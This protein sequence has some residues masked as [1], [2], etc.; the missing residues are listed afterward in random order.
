MKLLFGVDPVN[1][2]NTEEQL[3]K[4]VPLEKAL[5][6]FD[7]K[8]LDILEKMLPHIQCGYRNYLV[9]FKVRN[10]GKGQSGCPVPGW[11]YDCVRDK[12]HPSRN[13]HHLL[14][15]NVDGTLFMCE[16]GTQIKAGDSQVWEYGRELHCAP[17]M[18]ESCKRVLIRLTGA[19]S[20]IK[21]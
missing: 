5:R 3:H 1:W 2:W 10:L 18:K 19:D 8:A 21:Y 14:Y 17:L 11:H 4:Y 16:D 9:D 7:S 15:T 20:V 12:N 13:E 6:C